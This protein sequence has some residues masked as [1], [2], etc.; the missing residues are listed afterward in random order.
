MKTQEG[1]NLVFPSH[2]VCA[3][4]TRFFRGSGAELT[5]EQ[6]LRIEQMERDYED[7]VARRLPQASRSSGARVWTDARG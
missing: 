3:A 4:I 5:R 7:L 6:K 1:F 2:Q